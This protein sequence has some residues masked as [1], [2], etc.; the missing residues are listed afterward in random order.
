MYFKK[1]TVHKLIKNKINTE[2]KNSL[3]F[4]SIMT[5]V[6]RKFFFFK[7]NYIYRYKENIY[8]IYVQYCAI[9]PGKNDIAYN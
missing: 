4:V 3:S 7:L 1:L 9:D 6:Y 8:T 2:N 5:A